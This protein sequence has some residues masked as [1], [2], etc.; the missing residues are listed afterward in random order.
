MSDM[1]E[2][3]MSV[4]DKRRRA[5]TIAAR[6]TA[7]PP[8]DCTSQCQGHTNEPATAARATYSN[9]RPSHRLQITMSGIYK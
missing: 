5:A 1:S 6:A 3:D 8:I 4:R 7:D 2:G 9:T